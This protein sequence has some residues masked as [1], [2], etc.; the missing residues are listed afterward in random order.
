[1]IP[2]YPLRIESGRVIDATGTCVLACSADTDC[3]MRFSEREIEKDGHFMCPNCGRL[4][5][6]MVEATPAQCGITEPEAEYCTTVEEAYN[7]GWERPHEGG[8]ASAGYKGRIYGRKPGNHRIWRCTKR[9]NEPEPELE[10]YEQWMGRHIG[11]SCDV[12]SNPD[13]PNCYQRTP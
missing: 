7:A 4:G 3:P 12:T 6:R 13:D 8:P 9:L 1:M 10:T 2:V 11:E 5:Q